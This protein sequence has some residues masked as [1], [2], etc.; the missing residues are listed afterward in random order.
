MIIRRTSSHS[1]AHTAVLITI[2]K[3]RLL[4]GAVFESSAAD[5]AL[6]PFVRLDDVGELFLRGARGFLCV[7]RAVLFPD[8]GV[9]AAVF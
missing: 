4:V 2:I 9:A 3:R 7:W 6:A 8:V 5:G 1:L